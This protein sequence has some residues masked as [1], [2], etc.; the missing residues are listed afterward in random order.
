M[1]A[2]RFLAGA[3]TLSAGRFFTNGFL[4]AGTAFFPADFENNMTSQSDELLLSLLLSLD[5]DELEESELDDIL[6]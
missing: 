1:V 6:N 5:D 3:S 2:G 4:A